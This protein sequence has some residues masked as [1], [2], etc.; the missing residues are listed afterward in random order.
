MG[1][2]RRECI[3]GWMILKFQYPFS[4]AK[5]Q[6]GR[7]AT[8]DDLLEGWSTCVVFCKS[9]EKSLLVTYCARY[10]FI[11]PLTQIVSS[12]KFHV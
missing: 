7:S 12:F 1:V 3:A 5:K 11:M 10:D 2:C 4:Q 6:A 8:Y 9:N